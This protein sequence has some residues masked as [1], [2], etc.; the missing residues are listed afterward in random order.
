MS[1][2][3][4]DLSKDRSALT[5]EDTSLSALDDVTRSHLTP[6]SSKGQDHDSR[7]LAAVSHL[8]AARN[9]ATGVLKREVK[10]MHNA[11]MCSTKYIIFLVG[12]PFSSSFLTIQSPIVEVPAHRR[13]HIILRNADATIPT[14]FIQSTR[15]PAQ[16]YAYRKG[17]EIWPECNE[18]PVRLTASFPGG[19]IPQPA[20]DLLDF[21]SSTYTAN[22]T[23][24]SP[25]LSTTSSDATSANDIVATSAASSS[26]P[27]RGIKRRAVRTTLSHILRSAA[28]ASTRRARSPSTIGK[29]YGQTFGVPPPAISKG[30]SIIAL[31]LLGTNCVHLHD[32]VSVILLSTYIIG[33]ASWCVAP[34]VASTPHHPIVN[35]P[36]FPSKGHVPALISNPLGASLTN[37]R[38][39]KTWLRL[40]AVVGV[41]LP[42]MVLAQL[43]I[44]SHFPILTNTLL[45][46]INTYNIAELKRI[47]GGH[48]FLLCWQALTESLSRA[49]LLPLPIRILIPVSYSALRISSLQSWAFSASESVMPMSIRTLG[50]VNILF[51]SAN[52]VFFLIPVGVIRYLRAHFYC[53]EAEEVTVRK[54]GESSVGL[55]P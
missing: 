47:I 36:S 46:N 12:M 1:V 19:V 24:I 34:K 5:S 37:S 21:T 26:Y 35:M 53:V 27:T 48:T 14:T 22:I 30:P 6:P 33:L 49:A 2:W 32:I 41:L 18:D 25:I 15:T 29:V 40:G 7:Q 31:I 44:S 28:Q 11:M 16:I 13:N 20:K 9:A 45:G 23:P 55:L 54:G 50:I 4:Q 39:Y 3:R 10:V 38:L 17:S 52:L 51:W 8:A 42:I 43:T